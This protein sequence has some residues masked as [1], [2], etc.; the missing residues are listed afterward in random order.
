MTIDRKQSKTALSFCITDS[1]GI[2]TVFT[3][4]QEDLNPGIH[5]Q[6]ITTLLGDENRT[7]TEFIQDH[8]K[9]QMF[10]L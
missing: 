3:K 6:W 2:N 5:N 8:Q 1:S 10:K 7:F 4:L 9:T